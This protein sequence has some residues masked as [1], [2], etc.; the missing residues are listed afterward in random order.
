MPTLLRLLGLALLLFSFDRVA[1]AQSDLIVEKKMFTIENFRL[2]SGAV[3]PQAV[4]AYETYGT[5]AADGRNALLLAHGFTSNHHAAGRYA[6]S[7]SETGW[8]DPLIGPGRAID[9]DRLFVIS[10]NMLGSSYGSTNPASLNPKTG[11]PYGPDFPEITLVDIVA[12]QK[13]L[14]DALGVKHLLAVAGPSYGGY[15][16]FQWGVTYPDM[17]DALVAVVSAPKG[18]GTDDR[19]AALRQRFAADPNWNGGWYY[20]K[21]GIV[22]T[23]TA[24]RIETLKRYGAEE[25]LAQQIANAEKREAA[26][27]SAAEKW[28]HEFDANGMLRLAHAS[29]FFD[30]EKDFAKMRAK[31]LYVLSST[32]KL[33]PPSIAP[34]VMGKLKAAGVDA[35]F[36]ELKSSYGHL[37]SRADADKWAPTLKAF[38][39]PFMPRS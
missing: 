5:L 11:K 36:F 9:T 39:A 13:R 15:Q 26:L 14:L 25:V 7:D 2:E 20:E 32:D 6:A 38:L 18:G 10:T 28:A 31:L 34:D 23:L 19:V 24:L 22:P 35:T 16:T 27:R 12:V 21:G 33:F 17:M 1:V 3:L 8:W 29:S 30:A 37:A 4:I